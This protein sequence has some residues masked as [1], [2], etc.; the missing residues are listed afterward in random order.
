[1]ANFRP[2]LS[3]PQKWKDEYCYSSSPELYVPDQPYELATPLLLTWNPNAPSAQ[4]LTAE[5]I[6]IDDVGK[7]FSKGFAV[8]KAR[9]ANGVDQY[10]LSGANFYLVACTAQGVESRRKTARVIQVG[11]ISGLNNERGALLAARVSFKP[12][13]EESECDLEELFDKWRDA[14]ERAYQRQRRRAQLN[15]EASRLLALTDTSSEP[16]RDS[17]AKAVLERNYVSLKHTLRLLKQR[18]EH[19]DAA[20][21]E[22]S[23]CDSLLINSKDEPDEREAHA[24]AKIV[25]QTITQEGVFEEGDLVELR[26]MGAD[27]N[28]VRTKVAGIKQGR[29]DLHPQDRIVLT[30]G[31]VVE[32]RKIPQFSMWAHDLA[33]D[34]L[35]AGDVPGRWEDLVTLLCEPGRLVRPF[36]TESPAFYFSDRDHERDPQNCKPLHVD[37]K[38][39]VDGALST[40]NAY[41]IQGPPGTGK[42][43]VITEIIRQLTARNERVLLLAPTHV[44]VDEVLVRIARKQDHVLP[45]RLAADDSRISREEVRRFSENSVQTELGRRVRTPQTTNVPSWERDLSVAQKTFDIIQTW[46]VARQ[47]SEAARIH[48]NSEAQSLSE[49][50]FQTESELAALIKA[51]AS[52][53]GVSQDLEARNQVLSREVIDQQEHCTRIYAESGWPQRLVSIIGVGSLGKAETQLANIRQALRGTIEAYEA[54]GNELERLRE[55]FNRVNKESGARVSRQSEKTENN[56]KILAAADAAESQ[57]LSDAIGTTKGAS[58]DSF[59]GI[60]KQAA[61]TIK[62]LKANITLERRW[63]DLTGQSDNSSNF[64]ATAEDELGSEILKYINLACCTTTGIASRRLVKEIEFD[65]LIVDEASRVTDSEFLI[66]AVRAKRWI[67]VGDEHQL[68]PYVQPEDEHH[69]HALAA[70]HAVDSKGGGLIDHVRKLGA[71]WEEDEELHQFREHNVLEVAQRLQVS[72]NWGRNYSAAFSGAMRLFQSEQDG[73]RE[74]LRTMRQYLVRSLFERCVSAESGV[75]ADAKRRLTVQ[76]RMIE[77]IAQL[78][79]VPIYGGDYVSPSNGELRDSGIAPLIL[80]YFKKPV[81]FMDTSK[82]GTAAR[83]VSLESAVADDLLRSH[84]LSLRDVGTNGFIN[85]LEAEWICCVCSLLECETYEGNDNLT[86]SVL[87]F[88]RAQSRLI[89]S[90]LA[91]K[92]WR[93][94]RFEVVDAIDKIQGQESDVVLISFCR[95]QPERLSANQGFGK[96][97]KDYRRLNVAV[98]RAHR[99]LI[100]VGHVQT[101]EKLS[102]SDE[103]SKAQAFYENLWNLL[104]PHN[105]GKAHPAMGTIHDFKSGDGRHR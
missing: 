29:I 86:V 44:A 102:F 49:I 9:V 64:R 98:T 45:V 79:S 26:K 93:R 104:D 81:L 12:P 36:C 88:Y 21:I 22:G 92:T 105:K 47:K 68:P 84:G 6:E 43:T 31:D 42:T 13:W 15:S 73:Q 18:S 16:D 46:L 63:F 67:L 83:E 4:R 17:I 100:M 94:I 71:M 10:K 77:P 91:R 82:R 54:T 33:L 2:S 40:Q 53:E 97:L 78:V 27:A 72:G 99:S 55:T 41:F 51:I 61:A 103:E 30:A 85:L 14:E 23:I 1:M 66:G 19:E 28:L 59:A 101:L 3:V 75:P 35:L 56:V 57:A 96:W 74:L 60:L 25:V 32:I 38:A 90:M 69:L 20:S 52:L 87:C 24:G 58:P 5:G 89:K 7:E 95:A 62:R 80:P 70:L 11:R 39:A 48:Y 8:Q 76:R 37:Q 50:Q 65:V 34:K